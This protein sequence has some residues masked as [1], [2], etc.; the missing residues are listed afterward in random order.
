MVHGIVSPRALRS[1]NPWSAI[2]FKSKKSRKKLFLN[3]STYSE[4]S[5]TFEVYGELLLALKTEPNVEI[6]QAFLDL[7]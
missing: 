4:I 6:V 3:S 5:G 1:R 7:S 2:Q